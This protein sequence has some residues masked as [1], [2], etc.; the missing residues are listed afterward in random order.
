[1]VVGTPAELIHTK[2][3]IPVSPCIFVAPIAEPV[4]K[5]EIDELVKLYD[6][7]EAQHS[8]RLEI[9]KALSEVGVVKCPEGIT[10]RP[11]PPGFSATI[12]LSHSMVYSSASF[13]SGD[14]V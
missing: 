7:L 4:D 12:W 3:V 9:E 5:N 10:V 1:M 6:Q 11:T 14:H 13:G 8:G 2:G